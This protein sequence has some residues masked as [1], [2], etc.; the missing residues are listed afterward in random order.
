MTALH[1]V[2][3]TAVGAH[4][5]PL[6]SYTLPTFQEYARRHGYRVVVADL[7]ADGPSVAREARFAKLGF[8]R[9]QL[10]AGA[11]LVLWVDVDAIF[12][13]FDD[14]I[15]DCVR[16]SDFQGLV[17]QVVPDFDRINPNTGVWVVR[18]RPTTF[19]FLR[20][21]EQIGIQPGEA[22]ADQAACMRALGF[23]M[24]SDLLSYTGAR[25]G[26]GTAFSGGT[27]WL[28]AT[29]NTLYYGGRPDQYHRRPESSPTV[30][31]PHVLHLANLPVSERLGIFADYEAGDLR[32]AEQ[33]E[34]AVA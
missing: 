2:L 20:R 32:P 23:H 19:R 22:W 8:M 17:F 9:A 16:E 31:D 10:Q 15:A 30:T 34:E 18:N 7:D 28:P 4:M 25:P 14:D 24:G 27:T 11:D 5:R 1:K 12:R 26:R 6:L 29:F 33:A 3:L 21:M 13:R